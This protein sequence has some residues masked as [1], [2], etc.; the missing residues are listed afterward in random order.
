MNVINRKRV[1]QTVANELYHHGVLGMK[2]GVRRYQNK[3]GSLTKQGTQ[4]YARDA[5]EK[6]YSKYDSETG[7]YYKVSKKNGRDD[8]EFDPHRYTKENM[9]RTKRLADSSSKM[10]S[11][12]KNANATYDRYRKK[13]K[14]DL[15]KM[16][17]KEMRDRINREFLERQYDDMFNPQKQ[18][19]G[20]ENVDVVLSMVG[21]TVGITSS[22][23]GI[24]LAVKELSG[25]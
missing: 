10:T 19:K 11:E 5:R 12:L 25:R 20:K 8:L 3:D 21:T 24:A 4:R 13:E 1:K 7:K 22:A 2:W 16:S 6:G 9:E 23:L 17:D 18:A 15:S 14:M